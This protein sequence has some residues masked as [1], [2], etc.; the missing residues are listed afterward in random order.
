MIAPR[1]ETVALAAISRPRSFG[2]MG[3]IY[4]NPQAAGVSTERRLCG[5]TSLGQMGERDHLP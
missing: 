1:R 3:R 2:S 4:P 5:D